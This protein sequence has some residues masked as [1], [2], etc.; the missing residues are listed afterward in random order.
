MILLATYA[1][2]HNNVTTFATDP[3]YT[4]APFAGLELLEVDPV[5]A[6]AAAKPH[7][8]KPP[9]ERAADAAGRGALVFTNPMNNGGVLYVN[10]ARIGTI[11]PFAT[12]NLDGFAAGW[13]RVTVEQTTGLKRTF[14]VEVA[15]K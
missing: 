2:A 10:E 9:G 7:A 3:A 12:V 1:L 5:A 6:V 11:G 15:A 4:P 13:Y 8:E 14:S